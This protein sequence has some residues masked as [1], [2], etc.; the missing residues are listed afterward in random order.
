MAQT[1]AWSLIVSMPLTPRTRK[2]GIGTAVCAPPPFRL[3]EAAP[4]RHDG[5]PP[6]LRRFTP[7]CAFRPQGRG[8]LALQRRAGLARKSACKA[9]RGALPPDL[10]ERA[11][12]MAGKIFPATGLPCCHHGSAR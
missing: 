6:T 11:S 7:L 5:L 1:A 10:L 9:R 4:A 2:A 12:K 3:R 8:A